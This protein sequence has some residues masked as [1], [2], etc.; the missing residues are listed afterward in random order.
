MGKRRNY[1][2]QWGSSSIT[3]TIGECLYRGV[4]LSQGWICTNRA[5]L[6]HNE[7]SG[8]LYMRGTTVYQCC[9]AHALTTLIQ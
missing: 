6:G 3:A 8:G 2:L 5:H 1:S 4:A 7:V 9:S